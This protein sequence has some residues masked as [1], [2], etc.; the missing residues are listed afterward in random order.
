MRKRM[1]RIAAALTC[2]GLMTAV[3]V[4]AALAERSGADGNTEAEQRT[5]MTA[6][7][8]ETKAERAARPEGR[9]GHGRREE[10]AE[11]E[12]AIGRDAAKAAALADAGITSDQA[13]KLRARVSD[14]D[15]ETV[16]RVSFR[17]NGQ[18]YSYKIDP[19]TGGVLDKAVSDAN[20]AHEHGGPQK[21]IKPPDARPSVHEQANAIPRAAECE[22]S[23]T[24]GLSAFSLKN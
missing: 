19:E 2:L 1:K 6:P 11:P 5:H 17:Y 24:T 16:Y 13:E 10:A 3:A 22:R 20:E 9:G 8:N 23:E 21:K 7:A 18:K 4:P 15:G 14:R 12:N